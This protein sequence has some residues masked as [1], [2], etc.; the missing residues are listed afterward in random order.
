MSVGEE[1]SS[2]ILDSI[3]ALRHKLLDLTARNP[4]LSFKHSARSF[5]H[6]RIIDEL[7]NQLFQNLS[8]E[9]PMSFRSL[10]SEVTI[11]D[12][13]KSLEF[14]RALDAA[15]LND[16]IYLDELRKLNDDAGERQLSRL[17][18]ELRERL[19]EQLGM[20]PRRK[21]INQTVEDAARRL[22]LN[23]SYELPA[24]TSR[25]PED[26]E[27]K[28]KD[29]IIQ[30]LLFDNGLDRVLFNIREKARLSIEET[31]VNP[32]YCVFG[33]LEWY[34]DASSEVALLAPLLLLPLAIQRELRR[35][36]YQYQVHGVGDGAS[37]N[38][39][40]AERLKRD[41]EMTLPPLDDDDN[42]ESYFVRVR[43][44][45]SG[46]QNWKVHRY[47]TI[48][49]FSFA[50]IAM[51][52]DLNPVNWSATGGIENHPKLMRILAGVTE[53]NWR[54]GTTNVN[55][56]SA[57]APTIA[58][59]EVPLI[60]DADSS[61]L[62]AIQE[63]LQGRD[64]VINGPPGTGKSQ[65]ITNLIAATL[66]RGKTVLFIAEKM[67]ALSVVR[68]RLADANLDDFC[69][70]LHSTKAGRKETADKLAKRLNRPPP[71]DV[72]PEL[73]A[74]I[75]QLERLHTLLQNGASELS[76]PAGNFRF[77]VQELLWKCQK[78]RLETPT[79]S[80]EVDEI[81]LP[82]AAEL[83]E[84]ELSQK[85]ALIE[86]F[87]AGRKR[88]S[89]AS[90][91]PRH[92]P[93][94]GLARAELDPIVSEDIVRRVRRLNT[95]SRQLQAIASILE[96][97]LGCECSTATDLVELG[98]GIVLGRL[99]APA[100]S[101]VC[102]VAKSDNFSSLRTWTIQL[103]EH[104]SIQERLQLAF[105][106]PQA[107]EAASPAR[108]CCLAKTAEQVGL[109]DA[110][111]KKLTDDG[112]RREKELE[113]WN[114]VA[115]LLRE[116]AEIV[117][118][119]EPVTVGIE[120][121][122]V[123]AIELAAEADVSLL[124]ARRA[125]TT[126]L[127]MSA[128]VSPIVSQ[129][130]KLR[131]QWDDL[132][133]KFVLEQRPD[134]NHLRQAAAALRSGSWFSF[135]S[136]TWRQARNVYRG[137]SRNPVK[138]SPHEMARSLD[139]IASFMTAS[140]AF[141]TDPQLS[142]LLGD[143]FR[144]LDSDLESLQRVTA[145]AE[146][147]RVG[148]PG[149]AAEDTCIRSLLLEGPVDQIRNLAELATRP[150]FS[151]LKKVR[152]SQGGLKT[153][154]LEHCRQLKA[155]LQDQ[156]DLITLAT[157]CRL[158]SHQPFSSS[159]QLAQ[160]LQHLKELAESI[161]NDSLA[162]AVL[163]ETFH[164]TKTDGEPLREA[165][166]YAAQVNNSKLPPSAKAWLLSAAVSERIETFTD[167]QRQI[168]TGIAA[169]AQATSELERVSAVRWLDWIKSD[170][171]LEVALADLANHTERCAGDPE[172]LQL[173]VDDA[174][175][176]NKLKEEGLGP[177]VQWLE[178]TNAEPSQ[179]TAI[180]RR[181]IFQS[182]AR[183]V[184]MANPVL[185]QFSGDR[186]EA[187]RRQF[188]ELDR[189]L[190]RLRQAK[191]AADLQKRQIDLGVDSGPKRSWT[192][193]ALIK[194]EIA[195]QKQHIPVRALLDRA[196]PAIQQLMPCFMM[197][198]L[199]VAQ[200]LRPGTANFD[201]VVMDEASQ[202]RPEDALGAIIRGSQVV[203][204]GDP[205]QLPPTSFF[206]SGEWTAEDE[207]ESVAQDKSIL[208]SAEA[209]IHPTR[210]LKW[211]YRSRHASLIAFSNR[212]FYKNELVVFPTPQAEHSDF[213]IA[214]YHVADAVYGE[215][216]NPIEGRVVAEAAVQHV[217]RHPQRSLGIVTL[218]QK[219]SELVKLEIDRLAAETP[220]FE[221]WR[222]GRENT[223]EPFFVK[224]L[225]NVQGDERDTIFIATVYGKDETGNL[226]RR[227]GPINS[228]GGHRRL[229]VL[230]TRAKCQIL[231]Y[232]S[233][234]PGDIVVD[235]KSPWGVRAL[236]G[237]LQYAKNRQADL[238]LITGRE[239][240]SEFEVAVANA[241]RA[242]GHD[243]KAQI[244]VVGYFI[245]LAVP[246]PKRPG[247]FLLGIE[248]DGASYHSGK[249]VRDRDRLR[250]EILERLGWRIHRIWSLDWFR[251][252]RR[253]TERLLRA[254]KNAELVAD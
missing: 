207:Q 222:R 254:L 189:R 5:Q 122:L 126:A 83:T 85:L 137:L 28:H 203:V 110:T 166:D 117:D 230:F 220:A 32:L 25:T 120:R 193:L 139:E 93:W 146:H 52:H 92:H 68:N 143:S 160:E 200:Y 115:A 96:R 119:S 216:V 225:E 104:A 42:P 221:A 157:E 156:R 84:V 153:T 7:P 35:G 57:S 41:F 31:G 210:R 242:S 72:D 34:E 69:L 53:A 47:V 180:C 49:L 219:Q 87:E 154:V 90:G 127:G 227:F 65:T 11:P 111:L 19:R 209:V 39:A 199:S 211:H 244:G 78:A 37:P 142:R 76:K 218:N 70:E 12:D 240:D 198:P 217:L 168:Q 51:Y 229:N 172:G 114:G 251:N 177:I 91:I 73:R 163:A 16:P 113:A 38:A 94:H 89:V 141:E 109:Q 75:T 150:Q 147:V 131:T 112:L 236:K 108:L 155:R 123:I 212:E 231:V 55:L 21:K 171:T 45:I 46:K 249:S 151:N 136:P 107:I 43:T 15:R 17:D 58:N 97:E 213:G 134:P 167:W 170:S 245:D 44:M 105:A 197:S 66:A 204:V 191:I 195:K 24:D 23:P 205:M 59:D 99:S 124:A 79:V 135:L 238:F 103:T 179:W 62:E 100:T 64:L 6:L 98:T 182:L 129:A 36:S 247:E 121:L 63:V 226:Y 27:S 233:M 106:N 149:R 14:R 29:T 158:A 174:R 116:A 161:E 185:T 138:L 95:A 192:N 10:G 77:T 159:A 241:L 88:I 22:N 162:K 74:T 132:K 26:R 188:Q 1:T 164:G 4:L 183:Q 80:S 128:I 130:K 206:M 145:W 243:V 223:L 235:E 125:E 50:R 40:L 118:W 214:Y 8:A 148:L 250:Q 175:L 20:V 18:E 201:L 246:N 234:D 33:F 232:S 13:E 133:A 169:L 202:L 181:V 186:H 48:G 239:P 56:K 165:L 3:A 2:Y 196:L 173:L 252:P 237:F 67:A 101:L 248:C 60:A 102:Q 152:P 9:S 176:L 71:H 215:G 187:S 140:A 194:N 184:L 228:D 144:G 86:E 82:D 81:T 54:G 61:Q 178:D 190:L 208:E 30:T 253:E 224:N